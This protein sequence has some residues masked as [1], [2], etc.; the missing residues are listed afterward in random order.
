MIVANAGDNKELVVRILTTMEELVERMKSQGK[1]LDEYQKVQV[2]QSLVVA[3][4]RLVEVVGSLRAE[5]LRGLE[6]RLVEIEKE[7]KELVVSLDYEKV[8]D[9][10]ETL[11]VGLAKLVEKSKE[12]GK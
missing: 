12:R 7:I 2:V 6:S 5:D 3:K 11:G 1:L 4:S 8:K 9:I 10:L